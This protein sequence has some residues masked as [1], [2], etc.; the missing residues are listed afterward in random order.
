MSRVEYS[1]PPS[2]EEKLSSLKIKDSVPHHSQLQYAL[3]YACCI[4]L[5]V[6][7]VAAYCG[8]AVI[9]KYHPE[10]RVT[11]EP[12]EPADRLSVINTTLSQIIGTVRGLLYVFEES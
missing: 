4:G 8:L 9:A 12:G 11:V 6:I 5:H 7:L 10:H 3:E 1:Q 2:A